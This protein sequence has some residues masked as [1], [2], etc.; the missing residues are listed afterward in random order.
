M[1]LNELLIFYVFNTGCQQKILYMY[2][3][4]AR[5]LHIVAWNQSLQRILMLISFPSESTLDL[6]K[7]GFAKILV[8]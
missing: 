3:Y 1:G 8:L 5:M 6:E 7:N 2:I 4:I